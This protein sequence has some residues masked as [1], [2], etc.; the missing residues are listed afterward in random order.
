MFWV[1]QNYYGMGHACHTV[2][3]YMS[4]TRCLQPEHI[5]PGMLSS[6]LVAPDEAARWAANQACLTREE[7][8]ALFRLVIAFQPFLAS[9]QPGQ[10]QAATQSMQVELSCAP[11]DVRRAFQLYLVRCPTSTSS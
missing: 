11:A 10:L 8:I 5:T 9:A 1:G 6:Y 7:R 3:T 4:V 2:S